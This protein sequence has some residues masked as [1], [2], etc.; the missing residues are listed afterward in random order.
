M[1]RRER[2]WLL[3][4]V[5]VTIAVRLALFAIVVFVRQDAAAFHTSDSARYLELGASLGRF[6]GF[7]TGGSPE[8]FRLPGFPLLVAV[9]GWAGDPTWWTIALHALIGAITTLIAFAW[10]RAVAGVRA[11][12]F[13]AWL[14]AC[15]PGQWVWSTFVLT[16]TLF[17][18]LFATAICFAT[19]YLQTRRRAA[20]FAAVA[21]GSAA[22][23]VRL[24]GYVV[25]P[26][27]V[28]ACAMLAFR[29]GSRGTRGAAWR[30][31]AMA[32]TLAV[33]LLGVWHVRNGLAA[34][35]WGFSIQ[36]E[37]AAY[38][39]GG[40][41]VEARHAGSYSEA[42]RALQQEMAAEPGRSAAAT[43]A[44]M[45]ERGLE[46]VAESPL[47]FL[48]TYAAGIVTT[49]FHP[50][51]GAFMRLL[52]PSDADGTASVAQM[53]TLG[54][55]QAAREKARA[56][57]LGYWVLAVPLFAVTLVYVALFCAGAWAGRTSPPVVL[58]C[59]VA[60]VMLAASGGPDG[61][62][63]RRAPLVPLMCVVGA[64]LLARSWRRAPAGDGRGGHTSSFHA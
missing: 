28:L 18:A 61:D 20:L 19:H 47:A 23:Y 57:S 62:S 46:L 9:A 26:M 4:A 3:G 13:A 11:G 22:A 37:R 48:S 49:A 35:Y 63:R 64:S 16:E 7:G 53:L 58:A 15:E 24:I 12:L 41:V 10:G 27:L 43:A 52:V 51:S 33:A 29:A 32:A 17:T 55:W 2:A 44:A 6:D 21:A 25:P 39:L 50:G 59:L 56:K 38:L 45:R 31:A 14:Y 36:T 42:R 8:L 5:G 40:G 1:S 30:D 54:R 60:A 34:G